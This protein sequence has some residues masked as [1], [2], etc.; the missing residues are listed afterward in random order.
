MNITKGKIGNALTSTA[1]DHIV[2]VA[3]DIYDESESKYQS[4]LNSEFSA[5]KNN[6]AKNAT[7]IEAEKARAQ[8]AEDK[9][10][11]GT[12]VRFDGIEQS[13]I[14]INPPHEGEFAASVEIIYYELGKRF[15]YRSSGELYEVGDSL[16]THMDGPNIRTDKIYLLGSTP[17]VWNNGSLVPAM[18]SGG[19]PSPDSTLVTQVSQ[20]T[21]AISRNKKSID[22]EVA[23]AK[24]VEGVLRNGTTMRFDGIESENKDLLIPEAFESD[25]EIIYLV[26]K[27]KFVYRAGTTYYDDDG[28]LGNYNANGKIR[29]DKL[30]LLNATIYAWN[31]TDLV[32]ASSTGGGEIDP[33][34]LAQIEANTEDINGIKDAFYYRADFV[35]KIANGL[36]GAPTNSNSIYTDEKFPGE[37]GKTY[38]IITNRPPDDGCVYVY[39]YITYDSLAGLVQEHKVRREDYYTNKSTANYVTLQEGEV[40]FGFSIA[41]WD[42]SAAKYIKLRIDN[43]DGYEIKIHTYSTVDEMEFKVL[44][45]DGKIDTL[46]S[47][48][49][50][51]VKVE[52]GGLSDSAGLPLDRTDRARCQAIPVRQIIGAKMKNIPGIRAWIQRLDANKK[53]LGTMPNMWNSDNDV[54][55]VRDIPGSPTFINLVFKRADGKDITEE[56]LANLNNW[57][58]DLLYSN[59]ALFDDIKNPPIYKRNIDKVSHLVAMCRARKTNTSPYRDY[60]VLICTDS[61]GDKQATMNTIDALNSFPTLAAWI[62][63]GDSV[64]GHY[65]Q[66]SVQIFTDSVKK[67]R[68][69]FYTVIGNHDVGNATYVAACATHEQAYETF[70]KPSVDAGWL[71]AGE[72]TE[73]KPYW[74]HDDTT[75]KI[76]L[77]GLYEYDDP[78]DFDTE[79]WEPVPYDEAAPL[80]AKGTSYNEDDVVTPCLW[81]VGDNYFDYTAYSFRCKKACT[82]T[83]SSFSANYKVLPKYKIQ[84]GTRVIRQ[85]QAQWFLNTLASTP[86]GYG[87]IVVMH[88]P[89]SDTATTVEA[90]F[91]QTVGKTG[92]NFS[93]NLMQ[94]DFIR[95]AVVAFVKG[96]NYNEDVIMKGGAAYLNRLDKEPSES[97]DG[98]Q[99]AYNVSKDFSKK[100]SNVNFLG[101]VGGH[102]HWDL[103]WKD[104]SENI[105][106]ITPCCVSTAIQSA[107]NS[108]I[109]RT[110]EDGP[111]KDSLTAVSFA[112]GRIAL[113]KIG[114]NVTENGTARDYEVINPNA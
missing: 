28:T 72:Y 63:C 69:P 76:R 101:F 104:A 31:D 88:N 17:Y 109:R 82:I 51:P 37:V 5:A 114:V 27:Q 9:L 6:I 66:T 1:A 53:L 40:G 71:K 93:Q 7:A 21:T 74:Y 112:S 23:R 20:N 90:K 62:N 95:N 47:S 87:V 61:H 78:M 34:L 32:V 48:V 111:A 102:V 106:Q 16:P 29:K 98:Y 73:G 89:F 35:P 4:E 3:N 103:V 96:D 33:D 43:F 36:Q 75:Y 30:Y 18:G 15:V 83:N 11:D 110:S 2:A 19:G 92:A 79:Y 56:D 58:I 57:V 80:I 26:P 44:E 13:N 113:A 41:Q 86:A 67:A 91:T 59:S 84:R 45:H 105:Y 22:S 100:N 77:I 42:V 54:L 12:T 85:E 39:G 46:D 107:T 8:A 65:G 10:R 49:L 97:D 108:D 68:K 52:I 99:Y 70:I 94:T 38:S 60:Q 50:N 14:P 55:L 24:G 64:E 25:P 81:G